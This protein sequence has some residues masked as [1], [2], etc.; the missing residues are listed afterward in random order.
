MPPKPTFR[1]RISDNAQD[2]ALLPPPT[3][4]SFEVPHLPF[5]NFPRPDGQR[6][7]AF[8]VRKRLLS[9]WNLNI[10]G[11]GIMTGMN[12]TSNLQGLSTP[13]T[14]NNTRGFGSATMLLEGISAADAIVE[15]DDWLAIEPPL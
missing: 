9:D 13:Q 15:R 10:S 1:V 4:M 14:P 5:E 3:M 7:P 11:S 8:T 12:S 6:K 2:S